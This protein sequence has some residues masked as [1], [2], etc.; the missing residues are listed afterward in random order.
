MH[1]TAGQKARQYPLTL[2]PAELKATGF[3]VNIGVKPSS[4]A[5]SRSMA[6]VHDSGAAEFE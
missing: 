3:T 4:T 1:N 5:R 2:T 6:A